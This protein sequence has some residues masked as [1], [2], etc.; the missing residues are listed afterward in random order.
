MGKQLKKAGR[1]LPVKKPSEEERWEDR[2]RAFKAITGMDAPEDRGQAFPKKSNSPAP[3]KMPRPFV[4][5]VHYGDI[6]AD[7]RG[8]TDRKRKDRDYDSW[9]DEDGAVL[10]ACRTSR[11]MALRTEVFDPQ[12]N[13]IVA[14]HPRQYDPYERSNAVSAWRLAEQAKPKKSVGSPSKGKP[15]KKGK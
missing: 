6:K 3:G 7:R 10:F 9:L 11:D 13:S 2:K 15:L 4:V 14:F 1:K 8:K 5:R 12:G